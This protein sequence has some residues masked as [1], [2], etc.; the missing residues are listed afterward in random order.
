MWTIMTMASIFEN[1]V[2]LMSWE[3]KVIGIYD[4]LVWLI[5]PSTTA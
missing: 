2:R 4:H 1:E 5:G 3:E